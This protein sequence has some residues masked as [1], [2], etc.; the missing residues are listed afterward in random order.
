[1]AFSMNLRFL[2]FVSIPVVVLAFACGGATDSTP[3]TG[4]DASPTKPVGGETNT[5]SAGSEANRPA[6]VGA[7]IAP[8]G[9]GVCCPV[10]NPCGPGYRGG[11]AAK[12]NECEY[13]KS[14]DG[15][16]VRRTDEHGC[17]EWVSRGLAND[18][19]LCCLCV[20]PDAGDGG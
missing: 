6:A 9:D 2:L 15:S 11:W 12:A 1:M 14:W 19:D 5:G 16:H 10:E 13:V 3:S 20:A 4:D 7:T 18:A 8:G 17:E